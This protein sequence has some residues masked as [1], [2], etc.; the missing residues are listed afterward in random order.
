[1]A[2]LSF[3]E[4]KCLLRVMPMVVAP[5]RAVNTLDRA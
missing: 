2:L 1:M 4:G 5:H 3:D